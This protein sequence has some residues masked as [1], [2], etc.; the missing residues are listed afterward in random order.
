[1]LPLPTTGNRRAELI[2][3]IAFAPPAPFWFEP[4]VDPEPVA[5]DIKDLSLLAQ[6]ALVETSPGNAR[7][8]N[9]EALNARLTRA[10][11][12]PPPP[13]DHRDRWT[14]EEWEQAMA[15]RD[16]YLHRVH[17]H[18]ERCKERSKLI[19]EER[20]L[21]WPIY[22]AEDQLRRLDKLTRDSAPEPRTAF[23]AETYDDAVDL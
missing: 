3:L 16:D 4:L 5:P 10:V 21:Q 15:E 12:A 13:P 6:W 9:A 2:H 7:I 11:N 8:D 23:N 17:L 19:D 22:W 1:M 18:K 20:L 14:Q